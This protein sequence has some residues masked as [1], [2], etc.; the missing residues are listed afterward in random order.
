MSKQIYK[1]DEI[2]DILKR[3]AELQG[4]EGEG[5]S[6]GLSLPELQQIA[7]DSGIDPKYVH[8]AAAELA[9][10]P[11]GEK[12]NFWGGPLRLVLEREIEGE[13]TAEVWEK[14]V[15]EI[16]RSFQESGSVQEWGRAFEWTLS[17]KNSVTAHVTAIP[18]DGKTQLELHWAEPVMFV[19][20]FV[21]SLVASLIW[22]PILFESLQ[23]GTTGIPIYIA[24]IA[25]IW[26]IARVGLGSFA[27]R[28]KK[29][30]RKLAATLE[31]IGEEENEKAQARL[32]ASD[33]TPEQNAMRSIVLEEESDAEMT[34]TP[35][36][37]S[38]QPAPYL[39]RG[40]SGSSRAHR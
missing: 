34:D 7:I 10:V 9:A 20:F 31:S 2:S 36:P 30:L 39:I 25:A 16:R 32:E 5:P 23:L 19:P 15:S 11:E 17:G 21:P 14:M 33:V 35:S 37:S 3:A 38:R 18:R 29:R 4:S 26:T 13:I 8:L 6:T 28:R 27:K 22:L 1:Q 24:I 40:K 12:T